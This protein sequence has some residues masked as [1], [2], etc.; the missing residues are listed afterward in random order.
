V[1]LREEEF[2]GIWHRDVAGESITTQLKG[3]T[4]L[5]GCYDLAL[6]SLLVR[7][8]T[9]PFTRLLRAHSNFNSEFFIIGACS[10]SNSGL[11]ADAR[12]K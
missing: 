4:P 1:L 11:S 10:G 6:P 9:L 2:I 7:F 12:L 8:A 5:V 3:A